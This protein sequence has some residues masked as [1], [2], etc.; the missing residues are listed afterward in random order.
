MWDTPMIFGGFPDLIV[1]NEAAIVFIYDANGKRV[2]KSKMQG[3][4]IVEIALKSGTYFV[5]YISQS[6]SKISKIIVE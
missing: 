1:E 4:L 3:E 5:Q 6:S 2:L